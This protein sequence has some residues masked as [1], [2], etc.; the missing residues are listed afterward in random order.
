MK[1]IF[2]LS[3]LMVM[4]A[5]ASMA[6]N[7]QM[8]IMSG[9]NGS[10]YVGTAP[11][12]TPLPMSSVTGGGTGILGTASLSIPFTSAV[13]LPAAPTGATRC[14]I[15]PDQ[16][17]NW[18]NASV[19]SGLANQYFFQLIPGQGF[20]GFTSFTSFYLIGRTAVATATIIWE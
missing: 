10:V 8:K 14:F 7:A 15:M 20:F 5:S 16:D 4:V 2:L 9:T 18:G 12:G 1:R 17:V 3:L 6:E 11:D 13:A 19:T